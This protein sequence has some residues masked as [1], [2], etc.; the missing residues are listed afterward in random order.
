[1]VGEQHEAGQQGGGNA[2][3]DQRLEEE[4]HGV[5]SESLSWE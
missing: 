4:G 1:M 3:A 5:F 2:E